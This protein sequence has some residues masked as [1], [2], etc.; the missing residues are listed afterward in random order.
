MLLRMALMTPVMLVASYM[1]T[2]RASLQL[3]VIV[4]ATIP[5]IIIGVIIVA[6]ASKPISESCSSRRTA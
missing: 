6:R 5:V 1:M 4:A 2:L 3:S